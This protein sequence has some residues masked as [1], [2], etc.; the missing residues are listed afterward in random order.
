[1]RALRSVLPA[2]FVTSALVLSGCSTD[3]QQAAPSPTS[4]ET[5]GTSAN[6]P[7]PQE[8]KPPWPYKSEDV[9]YRSGDLTIAG[10]LT[11]P[12]KSGPHPAVLLVSGSGPQDRDEELL[13]HKPF[14][15]L[16]DTLTRA[17]YAVLRVD[18]RG[19]GGTGGN[20]DNSN[21][22]DL[23]TDIAA[24]LTYLRGRSEINAKQIGL[25]GHSE[26]GYLAPL[27]AGR[28]DS[29]VAFTILMAG[30]AVRGSDVVLEQTRIIM[31]AHGATPEQ[32]TTEVD[33]LTTITELL[34]AG[35]LEGARKFGRARND[36]LPADQRAT[37][38]E[39]DASLSPYFAALM[40][41]DPAPALSALR[42]PVLAFYGSKDLQVPPA[43]SEP[44]AR[45]LLAADPDAT[46]QVFDGL[47]HLMQPADKGLPSEYSTIE[48]T[49]DPQVL[50][51]V[52][53]WL[54]K[55]FP[56]KG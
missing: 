53:A 54:L 2:L 7:R 37:P 35:D 44:P 11:L 47:N 28:P 22:E 10:T 12:E 4:G 40:N 42:V 39:V 8:P 16:A 33:Y 41:Y 13:G 3:S 24:G 17:G 29:G 26:G 48:T 21:Y 38:A 32:I 49:I 43:Q 51:A 27:V 9:G 15:L 55:R 31:A 25:M 56:P 20:L 45:A 46:V 36:T 14:L 1:M 30:P 50:S 5:P 34:R 23:S 19:V 52:T 6:P 18:D